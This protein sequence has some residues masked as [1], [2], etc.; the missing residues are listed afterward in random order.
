MAPPRRKSGGVESSGG[1]FGREAPFATRSTPAVDPEARSA[2]VADPAA[3]HRRG[4]PNLVSRVA[5]ARV[6]DPGPI[7]PRY[8]F[9]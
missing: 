9:F 8:G 5:T 2:P 3:W 1:R 6:P 4:G 7:R